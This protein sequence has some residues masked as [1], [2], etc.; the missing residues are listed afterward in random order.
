MYIIGERI[1]GM[2]KDVEEAIRRNDK[3]VIV[4][5]ARKQLEAG[6]NA[7]DVNVGPAAANSIEAMEWLVNTIGEVTDATLAIDTTKPDVMEAGLRLC[8][9]KSIVNSIQGSQKKMDTFLPLASKYKSAVICLTI[10]EKGIPNDAPSRTE[11]AATLLTACLE[12]GINVNDIFIDAVIL[13]VSA[14]QEHS[15][16]V[17]ETIRQIKLLSDPAPKTILGL[18]N[19]SQKTRDRSLVN[20]VFMAM[21]VAAGLDAA[22]L[23]P[24]DRVLMNTM[25]TAELLMSKQIYCENY[26]EAY[27]KS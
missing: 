7:L 24:M 26:I 9:G 19:V 2:F 17:L 3:K 16:E 13:P 11:I 10:N 14:T 23:D 15:K 18:S 6:A 12:R 27:K 21:A 5:L 1:N 25:I 4:E 20:S 22:I 8:K